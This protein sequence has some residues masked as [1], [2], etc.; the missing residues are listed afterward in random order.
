M[1]EDARTDSGSPTPSPGRFQV[2]PAAYVLLRR[3]RAVAP[4][5]HDEVLLQLRRGTGYFDGHWAAGAAGHVEPGESVF[6]AA[7]REAHEELGVTIMAAALHPITAMH[8]TNGNGQ[9]IDERVDFFFECREWSGTP[10]L[11]E[12]KAAD[13]AWFPLDALPTPVVPHELFVLDGLRTGTLAATVAYG[14]PGTALSG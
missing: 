4:S 7:A 1:S 13:L 10:A 11:Q 8:R 9:P 12:D 14:F 5:G 6:A 2:I 3:G